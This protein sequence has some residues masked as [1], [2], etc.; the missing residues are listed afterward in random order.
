MTPTGAAAA[1][2]GS[3]DLLA[4]FTVGLLG[5]AHCLGMCGP[6]VS[7]YAKRFD[8][9]ADRITPREV[10]QH[11]LFNLGRTGGYA[12]VGGLFGL[13]GATV[14]DAGDIA[15]IAGVV[16][17]ATGVLA[18]LVVFGAGV[19]YLRGGGGG[20]HDLPVGNG[21][22]R[23]TNALTQ[24]VDRWAGGPRV[25]GLGAVHALLPCPLLYPAYLAAFAIGSP[26]RGALSLA[27]LG[28]GTLPALFLIGFSAGRIGTTERRRLHRALG[29]AF[30]FLALLPL[31]HGLAALGLPVPHV[32]E[33]LHVYIGQ[34]GEVGNA[35]FAL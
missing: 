8:D 25:V 18:G 6:L 22:A 12:V 19:T 26:T 2:G 16:R 34:I 23:V 31:S 13:L 24:R 10:R 11:L 35:L 15:G 28:A 1:L 5:G 20:L 21:F 29:L 17:G 27:V 14:F 9:D 32:S 3:L 30:V 7:L 4:F 33:L